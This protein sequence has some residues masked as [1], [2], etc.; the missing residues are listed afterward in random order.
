[1]N[2]LLD[3]ATDART[4]P[5]L[6]IGQDVH[7]NVGPTWVAADIT[8][9]THTRIGVNFRPR[10]T[11]P[12]GLTRRHRLAGIVAPWQVR[13]AHGVW[14]CPVHA[15]RAGDYLVTFAGTLTGVTATWLH[16]NPDLRIIDLDDGER[17]VRRA[18]AVLRVREDAPQVTMNGVPL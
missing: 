12:S 4:S 14:L 11:A 8:S 18:R 3:A 5:A 10:T 1:M 2:P 16:R 7:V 6:T 9:I 15:L 13:A 17:C